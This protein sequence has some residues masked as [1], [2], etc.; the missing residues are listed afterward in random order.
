MT[1]C[2]NLYRHRLSIILT[3]NPTLLYFE[4]FLH[5]LRNYLVIQ[6]PLNEDDN[7]VRTELKLFE[8]GC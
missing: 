8:D 3:L 5:N 7:Y 2:Q 6:F 4:I 1:E